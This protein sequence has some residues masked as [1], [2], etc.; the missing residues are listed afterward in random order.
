MEKRRIEY[1]LQQ[2][3]KE[4][5]TNSKRTI[6]SLARVEQIMDNTDFGNGVEVNEESEL[7]LTTRVFR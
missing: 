1:S 6:T 7:Y 4:S 5:E 2:L 3:K